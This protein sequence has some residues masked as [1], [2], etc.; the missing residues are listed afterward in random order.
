MKRRLVSLSLLCLSMCLLVMFQP[1]FVTFG[2]LTGTVAV[3]A[4]KL[5]DAKT[6]RLLENQIIL[7]EGDKVKRVGSAADV[8]IP[9]G[10][11]IIDLSRQTV[12]PGL[13]D[14]HTHL[15]FDP[16]QNGYEALGISVPRQA[17]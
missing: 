4:G 7:I 6:G 15:T 12:L 17:L 9:A 5:F 3:K 16:D 10:A 1:P 11:Q 2:Q 13:I 14:C 8:K